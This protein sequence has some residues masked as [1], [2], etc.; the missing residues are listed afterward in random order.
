[1]ICPR[2][3]RE[4]IP[5]PA[6]LAELV[7]GDQDVPSVARRSVP[8]ANPFCRLAIRVRIGARSTLTVPNCGA[9]RPSLRL[10]F[11]VDA[12][13]VVILNSTVPRS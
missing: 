10:A 4:A 13:S 7:F 5:Q 9:C 6:G 12:L 1:M 2:P 8:L 3:A 11:D